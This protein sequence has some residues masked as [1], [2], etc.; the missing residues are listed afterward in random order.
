[1]NIL[2]LS[3]GIEGETTYELISISN[4]CVPS[5]GGIL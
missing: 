5:D 2:R 1:M 4:H 3:T